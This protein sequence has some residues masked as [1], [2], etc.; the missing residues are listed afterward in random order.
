[1]FPAIG[2]AASV[3]VGIHAAVE[4]SLQVPAVAV[5]YAALLGLGVAQS[6]RTNMDLIR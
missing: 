2:F 5:V 1:V 4:F 3:V 6:W